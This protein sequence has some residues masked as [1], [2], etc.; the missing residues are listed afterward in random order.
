MYKN[1]EEI[2]RT[3]DR[4]SS[5]LILLIRSGTTDCNKREQMDFGKTSSKDQRRIERAF[6][7]PTSQNR[8]G[9]NWPSEN[10]PSLR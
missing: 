9:S 1:R 3:Y 4:L 8:P 5:S 10:A 2:R 7:K 6:E